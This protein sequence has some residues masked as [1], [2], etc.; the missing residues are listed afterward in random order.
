MEVQEVHGIADATLLDV[1][2]QA[3]AVDRPW[4]ELVVLAAACGE[5][6]ARLATLS[7]G[8]RD[9]LLLAARA[10]TFGRRM[11]CETTCGWCDARLELSL[12]AVELSV[13]RSAIDD[14]DLEVEAQGVSVRFR[15]PDS[16]DIAACREA[17]ADPVAQLLE[18]CVQVVTPPDGSLAVAMLPQAVLD[19]VTERMA[20]LDPQAEMLLDLDC[21]ECGVHSQT[22]FDPAAYFM[23]EIDARAARLLEEVHVLARAYGWNEAD[24]L[25][26]GPVR[27]RRY[28]ELATQ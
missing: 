3:C 18:R 13:S 16:T 19:A 8:E 7:I 26:L 5:T 17:A 4:R 27:R 9:R 23:A 21:P 22:S 15:L 6:P 24:V 10:R 20:V 2:E 14:D 25:A 1:W 11:D 12:D 28:L